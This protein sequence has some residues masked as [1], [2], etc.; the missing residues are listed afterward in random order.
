MT[1]SRSDPCGGISGA[2]SP[3]YLH[4][5]RPCCK[6]LFRGMLVAFTKH[7]YMSTG[8]IIATERLRKPGWRLFRNEIRA[9]RSTVIA[10]AAAD[11]LFY[12]A[13]MEVYAGA[14][15]TAHDKNHNQRGDTVFASGRRVHLRIKAAEPV[16]TSISYCFQSHSPHFIFIQ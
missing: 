14:K 3:A 8:Q 5:A 9:R 4:P 12:F 11:D 10:Q 15:A 2:Y 13:L 6:R 16:F 1:R 7:D